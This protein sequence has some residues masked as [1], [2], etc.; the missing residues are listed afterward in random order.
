MVKVA[1]RRWATHTRS[2]YDNECTCQKHYEK[3][4]LLLLLCRSQVSQPTCSKS[5]G[6]YLPSKKNLPSLKKKSPVCQR[7]K[8]LHQALVV[9]LAVV[10]YLPF[11]QLSIYLA[12]SFLPSMIWL[13]IINK[14]SQRSGI[15]V[16]QERQIQ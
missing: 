11:S 9:A 14:K 7:R 16:A 2:Q 10:R 1:F 3:M 8:K 5:A 13:L 6:Y 4:C 12:F 15:E